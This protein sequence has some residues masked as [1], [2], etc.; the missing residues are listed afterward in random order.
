MD[1][2]IDYLKYVTFIMPFYFFVMSYLFAKNKVKPSIYIGYSAKEQF[3]TGIAFTFGA[4][5]INF[6]PDNS[7]VSFVFMIL[8]CITL[9]SA[10]IIEKKHKPRFD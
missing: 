1:T 2:V 9:I 6:M 5:G 3:I 7:D 10:K 4:L 8:A